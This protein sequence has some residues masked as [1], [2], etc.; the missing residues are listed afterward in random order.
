MNVIQGTRARKGK[1]YVI[2]W[3]SNIF[4]VSGELQANY[5]SKTI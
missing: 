2:K 4:K 5:L 3:T 1:R